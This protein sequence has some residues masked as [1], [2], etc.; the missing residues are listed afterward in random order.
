MYSQLPSY[1][2]NNMWLNLGMTKQR[3][4]KRRVISEGYDFGELWPNHAQITPT[5]TDNH[6]EFRNSRRFLELT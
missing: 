2:L 5:F 3:D 1:V 6:T 4:M